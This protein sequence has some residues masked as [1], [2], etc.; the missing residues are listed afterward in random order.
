MGWVH[1]LAFGTKVDVLHPTF[2]LWMPARA[3]KYSKDPSTGHLSLL[4]HVEGFEG[5]LDFSIILPSSSSSSNRSNGRKKSGQNS[6]GT[7]TDTA[8]GLPIR[9]ATNDPEVLK[10]CGPRP[11]DE[12]LFDVKAPPKLFQLTRKEREAA[13]KGGV[14][15]AESSAPA[16]E[17]VTVAGK[18]TNGVVDM[19]TDNDG[20]KEN[21][22]DEGVHQAFTSSS[23]S[24]DSAKA[25]AKSGAKKLGV[26][27]SRKLPNAS[28]GSA[29]KAAEKPAEVNHDDEPAAVPEEDKEEHQAD[30]P[31]KKRGRPSG[32]KL[33]SPKKEPAP[34]E[35]PE[36][37]HE[38]APN[39]DSNAKSSESTKR[40]RKR[41]DETP[42]VPATPTRAA[43]QT[44]QNEASS[45]RSARKKPE[46]S[47]APAAEDGEDGEHKAKRP[48]LSA[49][50]RSNLQLKPGKFQPGEPDSPWQYNLKYGE[51]LEVFS[52]DDDQWYP[53]RAMYYI[54]PE[55]GG[56]K[57]KVHYD[58]FPKKFDDSVD[59][60]ADS[61]KDLRIR[62][63]TDDEEVLKRAGPAEPEDAFDLNKDHKPYGLTHDM[64]KQALAGEILIKKR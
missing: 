20:A 15:F 48:R 18:H 14:V 5:S 32:Q 2:E 31:V 7:D 13:V 43:A 58:G 24:A 63:P 45:R 38:D 29:E 23:S 47:A 59:L 35:E 57:L 64:K 3:I 44:E 61:L 49:P 26:R 37:E 34:A 53:G 30:A 36:A 41:K 10:R 60:W 46:E 19:E 40:G 11:V 56:V 8:D 16:A 55:E 28:S 22:A 1:E 9:R 42:A 27:G 12:E 25:P 21:G 51:E 54:A 4:V 50:P 33:A 17:K 62:P 39:D 52:L 6:N